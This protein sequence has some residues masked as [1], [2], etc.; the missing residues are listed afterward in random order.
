MASMD[1]FNQNAFSMVSMT[2]GLEKVPYQPSFLR[3]LNIFTP[4]PIR[5]SVAMIEEREGV[6]NLIKTSDRGAPIAERSTEKRKLRSFEV[7]RIAKGDT[8]QASEIDSIRAFGSESELMQVQREIARRVNGPT[9]L[10]REVEMTW[11]HMMLG[12]VQGILVDSDGS[13]LFNYYTEFGVPQAAE[14]DFDL[15]NAS[16]ASGAVRKKCNSVLRAMM[17]NAQG[18]WTPN[19][20]AMGLCGDAFFDDLTAHSEVRET[21]LSQSEAGMLRNEVGQAYSAVRYGNITF[22]NYRGTDDGSTISIGTDK[23]V[24]FPVNAPGVFRWVKSPGESLD[25]VNTLGRDVYSM[26]IR[27]RDR[28]AWVRPEVYSY[29]LMLCTRPGM[30]QR[31]K[32]T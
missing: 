19:T 26:L 23:C 3:N 18:T 10:L 7:P 2:Q 28:N 15:D 30:L 27:D 31:A 21:Y 11:E 5:T 8:I 14:I 12:A 25:Y 32:R 6:L 1:I 16:P 24:F 29:P 17:D 20:T 4:D 22:V 13:T 9:G